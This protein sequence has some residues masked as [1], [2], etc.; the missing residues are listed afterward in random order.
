MVTD[1][2]TSQNVAKIPDFLDYIF[3]VHILAPSF[4]FAERKTNPL[5]TLRIACNRQTIF[6]KE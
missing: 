3:V 2:V 6:E 5:I 1:A 4:S